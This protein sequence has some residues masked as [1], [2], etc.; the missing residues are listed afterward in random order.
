MDI[1][2]IKVE[3]SSTEQQQDLL[4]NGFSHNHLKYRCEEY[5]PTR[6]LLQ[7][8][9]CQKY[10]HSIKECQEKEDTCRK[11]SQP[12]K[13][14]TCQ[15]NQKK[16]ANCQGSHSSTFKGCKAHQEAASARKT[17]SLTYA[18]AAKKSTLMD[19][20]IVKLTIALLSTFHGCMKDHP[21]FNLETLSKSVVSS[22]EEVYRVGIDHQA[23][24]NFY[25]ENKK[26]PQ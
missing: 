1:R 26:T 14:S 10:G 8:Y 17:R 6:P 3:C 18:Q 23:L 15:E 22:M 25:R 19:E 16:C 12:H 9:R 21:N 5:K 20:E 11:C 7:C 4:D 2:K 24:F 13:T